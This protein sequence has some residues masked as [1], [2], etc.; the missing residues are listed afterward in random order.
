MS[1]ATQAVEYEVDRLLGVTPELDSFSLTNVVS[2]FSPES[3]AKIVKLEQVLNDK[4]E[5]YMFRLWAASQL[6]CGLP[7]D[8]V[9]TETEFLILDRIKTKEEADSVNGNSQ[10]IASQAEF[11]IWSNLLVGLEYNKQ[12]TSQVLDAY[13]STFPVNSK[14]S[15]P[16]HAKDVLLQTLMSLIL[17]QPKKNPLYRGMSPATVSSHL[18]SICESMIQKFSEIF[19]L[20]EQR[21]QEELKLK[22]EA[23]CP[24]RRIKKVAGYAG[25]LTLF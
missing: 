1:E 15:S 6:V 9:L 3:K 7:D 10:S 8:E 14:Q 13:A 21:V 16:E 24:T 2:I 17:I 20:D 18:D 23:A 22:V 11:D 19:S 25:Q 5:D 4:N 12:L